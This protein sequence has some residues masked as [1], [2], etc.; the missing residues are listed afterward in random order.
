MAFKLFDPTS[1]L[2]D[3]GTALKEHPLDQLPEG[4]D[5]LWFVQTDS[6][7]RRYRKSVVDFLIAVHPDPGGWLELRAINPGAPPR[8]T[9]I[10]PLPLN[11]KAFADI[12]TFVEQA[13][14]DK[15]NVY[16]AIA[17]RIDPKAN[18]PGALENCF[19]LSAL[20]I[21]I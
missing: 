1:G 19:N 12:K 21:D 5:A 2:R 15:R 4:D 14:D 9:F 8:R 17:S 10:G 6:I 18:K 16:H 11:A 7:T 20:Y 13:H 3:F